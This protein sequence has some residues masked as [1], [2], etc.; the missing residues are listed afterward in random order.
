M[1]NA[2]FTIVEQMPVAFKKLYAGN[3]FGISYEIVNC[4][5]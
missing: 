3:S 5:L 2:Q 1:H 4:A